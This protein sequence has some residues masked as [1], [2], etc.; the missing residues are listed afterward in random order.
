MSRIFLHW[1]LQMK[2]FACYFR[3]RV[4]KFVEFFVGLN[5]YADAGEHKRLKEFWVNFPING[6]RKRCV[7]RAANSICQSA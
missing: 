2:K 6:N 3:S 1:R 7:V 4:S 5:N